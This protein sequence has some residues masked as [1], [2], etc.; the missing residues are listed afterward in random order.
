VTKL[1]ILRLSTSTGNLMGSS[2]KHVKFTKKEVSFLLENDVCRV[3][4]SHNDIPHIVPVNYIQEN[5]FLYFATDYDTRKYHNLR[6][7]KRIAVTID[8]CD[9]SLDNRAV[10]IQGSSEFIERGKEFKRL[11]KIFEKKFEWVRNDPWR[12]GEAPF[13]RVQPSNKVSW[14]L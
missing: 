5:N 4:T 9:S 10:V 13:V 11:Y 3:A 14:G 8:V 2:N 12:E 6:K 7:N 1:F